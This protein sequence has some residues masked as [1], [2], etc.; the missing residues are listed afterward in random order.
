MRLFSTPFV[1]PTRTDYSF[2]DLGP[3]A[4]ADEIRDASSR[5]DQR[6][7]REKASEEELARAHAIRLESGDDRD[8]YDAAHP[9]LSLL[10]LLPTWD[11]IF[12]DHSAAIFVLRRSIED[13]LTGRNEAVYRPS[14]LTRTDFTAD[15]APNPLLDGEIR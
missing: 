8:E 12:D 10:K 6:L 1:L 2:L 9:P 7:R 13:H 3:E 14:D 4:T 5:L 15:H 11:P